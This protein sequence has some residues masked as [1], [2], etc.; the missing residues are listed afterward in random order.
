MGR[1]QCLG[2]QEGSQG[3]STDAKSE[4]PKK[5]PAAHREVHM[6]ALHGC[7]ITTNWPVCEKCCARSKTE[8]FARAEPAGNRLAFG[9][10]LRLYFGEYAERLKE[11]EHLFQDGSRGGI[12]LELETTNF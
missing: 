7:K 12:W 4:P 11:L 1:A 6:G 8:R 5:F 9:R 3:H 2:P 10:A